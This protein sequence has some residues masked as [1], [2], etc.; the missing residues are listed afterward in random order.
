MRLLFAA[1]ALL[2]LY[3]SAAATTLEVRQDAHGFASPISSSIVAC[4]T[5]VSATVTAA[6]SGPSLAAN[7]V[8]LTSTAPASGNVEGGETNTPSRFAWP[9]QVDYLEAMCAP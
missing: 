3:S 9:S 4:F 6:Y 2:S 7:T 1:A 5:Q 8:T